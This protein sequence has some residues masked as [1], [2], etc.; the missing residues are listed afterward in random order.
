MAED[1][2]RALP[3]A[4]SGPFELRS[5][6]LGALPIVRQFLDR[7]G[8]LAL[9]ERYLPG[10]DARVG[11]EAAVAIGVL[12]VNLCVEREPL[13]GIAAWAGSF[14]PGLLGLEVNEP[15]LLNDDRVGRGLDQL[16]DCDRAS[17]LTELVLG[18]IREFG[19]DCSRLHNDSTSITLYGEYLQA[20]GRER[21]GQPTAAAAR[22]HN[23]EH[24]G[25][26]KQ[27]LSILTVSADGAVPLA[28]RLADGNL[29]DDQ[30]HI[31][32]WDGLCT[33]TGRH[34][35]LYVADCKLCTRE[36][37]GHIDKRGGRFIT[38]LP[39]SRA[40]DGRLREW[41]TRATPDWVE[42]ERRPGKRKGSPDQV[43]LVAPAPFPTVEGYRI[44]WVHSSAKQ[45]RDETARAE[46]IDR[47]RRALKELSE[48][49]AGP[50]ARVT[51]RVAAEE[52]AAALLASTG[53]ERWVTVTVTE[54]VEERY[55]QEK[56]GRPGKDTRYRK[57]EKTRFV[58]EASVD[59]EHVRYDAASDGCF[60]LT[61]NDPRLT[62]TDAL[63]AYRYQPNLEKR[64]HELKSVQDAAPVTLK[65]PFR[66]EALFSCQFIALLTNC[67]IE[68]ELRHAMARE[69]IR[70][71][72]LYHEQRACTAPTAARIFD[73][74]AG[75]QRHH[76]IRDGRHVQTFDP[77][78][79]ALQLQLLDLLGIPASA[80]TN[81]PHR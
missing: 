74:F 65:S 4:A 35:F 58:L 2:Q 31:E 75:V 64:H 62:D 52:A 67:L 78:L 19:V 30:T 70:E 21:G 45:R 66:I 23:K 25:D 36:Q 8:L 44:T 5:V 43:W 71:L 80:Y 1:D 40:E 57:I 81:D 72:P 61:T 16:F 13:Y 41:M 17:L 26:L 29:T 51:T 10:G 73:H 9:F 56:R 48:R 53:T 27:L 55:R 24:R 6:R 63:A 39:R 20:D 34:D 46:R 15:G 14:P 11:L 38:V 37:M 18:A 22:G 79:T 60:P 7:L 77:E 47:A 69:G 28:L 50:R 49:L 12:V 33:L 54:T 68:R 76:L 3:A 59:A 32:T 42:A